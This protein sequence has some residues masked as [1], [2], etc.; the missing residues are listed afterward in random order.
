VQIT[1]LQGRLLVATPDLA[2]PNFFRTVI[3]LLEHGEEGSL[4]VAL[5][6]P[7]RAS[8]VGTLP[9]WAELISPPARFFSGGPMEP[10]AVIGL[11]RRGDVVPL[12]SWSSVFEDVGV[13]DLRTPPPRTSGLLRNVRVFS[14]YAGWGA[15][16]LEAELVGGGWLVTTAEA[17]D[18]FTSS[19]D[20]LWERALRRRP[21]GPSWIAGHRIPPLLN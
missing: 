3:L 15:S 4:G 19:P 21:W 2:D 20:S 5:N 8:A 1:S 7:T 17:A 9:D 16:Q 12:D 14:G 10:T 18:L 6:R 13:V 11:A